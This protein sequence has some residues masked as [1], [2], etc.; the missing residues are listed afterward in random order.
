[1]KYAFGFLFLACSIV[2]AQ[3]APSRP[4]LT[5]ISHIAVYASDTAAAEHYYVDIV[6]CERGPDPENPQGTRYYVNSTQ[7]IE[8]LPLA[9]KT[10]HN[11]LDHL[12]YKT[13]DAEKLRLY[14]KSKGIEVPSAV[15]KANDGSLWFDVKDPEGN[16]VQFVTPPDQNP[17]RHRSTVLAP[18][19]PL[20]T[21]KLA[22]NHIIHV[23]MLVHNRDT[24]DTFYRA[25]LGFRPYWH[26]GMQPDKT[27][28]VSQQ[29]P[30]SHDWLEYMLTS[31]PSGG[32][33][34]DISQHQL[35]VLN[36]LSIGV[37]SMAKTY[38][39]LK[40]AN[41]LAPPD[42]KTQ[43]GKDGKWQLNIYDPDGTRLEYMEFSNVRPPCCS[44]FTA[45]NPSPSE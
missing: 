11:R 17:Y 33:I 1:M 28:W 25:I 19:K 37:V 31:G 15:E 29:T 5:G 7:F 43:I 10:S 3:P 8:V 27:D 9:D 30:E 6:G 20:N 18:S 40:A 13:T 34:Q 21:S 42:S 36:H 41:R 44:E 32:G 14:L 16:T 12:A 24:E 4:P 26:G 35:G 38:D 22:G 39:T 23:G 45:P 2:S